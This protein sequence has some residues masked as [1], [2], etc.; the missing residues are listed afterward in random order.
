MYEILDF[1]E[2]II[3]F[4]EL[5]WILKIQW[6]LPEPSSLTFAHNF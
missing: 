2:I 5:F 4:Q 3:K 1:Y 6:L